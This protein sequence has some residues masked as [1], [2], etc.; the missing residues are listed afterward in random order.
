M[1][2]LRTKSTTRQGSMV[3]WHPL[4]LLAGL[5]TI[6]GCH[7][8]PKYTQPQIVAPPAYKELTG[9][10]ATATT[11][12]SAQPADASIR[13]QWWLAFKDDQLDLL[14]AQ[15]DISNQNIAEAAANYATA[16]AIVREARSQ[17]FPVA[18]LGASFTN[19]RVSVVPA[20]NL[21]S[22]AT[23]N[24]YSLPLEAS[25]EPDLW[26]KVRNSVRAATFQAQSTAAVLESVRLA[27][28]AQVAMDY[29]LARAQDSLAQVLDARIRDDLDTLEITRA[30][31]RAGLTT[32]E[33]L[34]AAEAQ[35]ETLQAQREN[36]RIAR[37]QYEHAIAV[38]LGKPA[39]VFSTPVA[40]FS[41]SA[42][43]V[44][45]GL[46]AKLLQRRPDIAAAERAVAAANAQIGLA[47]AA[48]FPDVLL[49]GTVG[50]T[51]ASAA[52]WL[53]W[54]S[55][56]WAVGPSVAET[57]FDAG[58]RR[59][60]VLEYRS[61]Y[62]SALA[63]YRQTTLTAFQQI[64]DN[65]AALRVL[66]DEIQ[67]QN[68]AVAAAQRVL[69]E[70]VTRYKSGLDP[71]LNVIQAEQALL[72]YQQDLVGLRSQQMSSTVQ[73]IQALGGGWDTQQLP[74]KKS[75]LEVSKR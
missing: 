53:T 62:N 74:D 14:E 11:W 50:L 73:L 72:S 41:G 54:P 40:A 75:I 64:E 23:Y 1:F 44:P 59:A 20:I 9:D 37:A 25:W 61:R 56:V 43:E 33:A 18:S 66:K 58:L 15:V 31:Y 3:G 13:S 51:A 29:Y 28:H 39:A 48:Y 65:L 34:S 19:N 35:L 55:R 49:S 2:T 10:E 70:A 30:L 6:S 16:S 57:I 68:A 47:R 22:G 36:V 52:N 67:Q 24:E 26:G 21:Q 45:A 60:T 8:S 69:N 17:Y 42:P 38:L 27:E 12:Q 63:A 4:V 7:I 5:S 32:D 71:Y 46:P